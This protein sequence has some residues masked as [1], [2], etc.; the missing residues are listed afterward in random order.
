MWDTLRNL[1]KLKHS[2][3]FSSRRRGTSSRDGDGK[4][5]RLDKCARCVQSVATWEDLP[6]AVQQIHAFI[7]TLSL[8]ALPNVVDQG[9]SSLGQFYRVLHAVDQSATLVHHEKLRQYR[10]AM[11][12]VPSKMSP[13]KARWKRC[14]SCTSDTL[15]VLTEEW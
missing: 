12:L 1:T 8:F 10:E 5:L 6:H 4:H 14:S 9:N 7:G 3:H 15:G 11:Y 2:S 13:K